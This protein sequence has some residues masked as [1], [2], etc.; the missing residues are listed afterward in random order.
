MPNLHN[1]Y[2]IICIVFLVFA[3]CGK[4]YVGKSD[5]VSSF[6]SYCVI[7]EKHQ[8]W[9]AYKNTIKVTRVNNRKE[10]N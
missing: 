7:N 4:W 1:V 6:S 5:S 8:I 2:P 10:E 9:G 3:K